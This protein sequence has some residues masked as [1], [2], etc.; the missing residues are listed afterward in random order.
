[1]ER[2][3]VEKRKCAYDKF[4]RYFKQINISDKVQLC[5]RYW[6]EENIIIDS[7]NI[8]IK[9][10]KIINTVEG[11]SFEGQ[12]LSGKKL[13]I[14]GYVS[15]KMYMKISNRCFCIRKDIP[16]STFIVVPKDTLEDDIVSLYYSIE[17]ISIIKTECN[18]MFISITLFLEYIKNNLLQCQSN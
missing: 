13:I 10:I 18:N 16:I 8:K 6:D 5:S 4:S 14:C 7:A 17:D 12:I 3:V 15:M 9:Y 1:M 2:F 11:I